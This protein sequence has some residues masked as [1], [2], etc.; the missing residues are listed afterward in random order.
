MTPLHAIA[1]DKLALG[2]RL[3][4]DTCDRNGV[5]IAACNAL[6]DAS[7]LA[8]LQQSGIAQVWTVGE[9]SGAEA[10]D[11][12]VERLRHLF[13]HVADSP[14]ACQLLT[15]LLVHRGEKKASRP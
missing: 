13:R 4:E 2:M 5:L 6:V 9:Q 1:I 12:E 10:S 7:S 14:A 11:P 15:A 3:G 8:R